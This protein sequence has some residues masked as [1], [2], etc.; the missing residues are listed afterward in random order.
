[1]DVRDVV[2]C[3]AMRFASFAV[4]CLDW[5]LS[6]VR[7]SVSLCWFVLCALAFEF[8][9]CA[10]AC[11]CVCFAWLV[12]ACFR[13]LRAY[14]HVFACARPCCSLAV[15]QLFVCS[16]VIQCLCVPCVPFVRSCLFVFVRV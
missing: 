16:S 3:A 1:M 9:L 7:S 14:L 12:H 8:G 11:V 10:C 2:C 5:F 13:V 4:L 15:F 6:F